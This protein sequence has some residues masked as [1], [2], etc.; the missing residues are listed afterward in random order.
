LQGISPIPGFRA[1]IPTLYLTAKSAASGEIPYATEQGIFEHLAGNF[2]GRTG[3][4]AS[5]DR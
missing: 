2:Q 4:F 5:D 3:N 1:P